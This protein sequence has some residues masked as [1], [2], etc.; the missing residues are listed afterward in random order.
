[1]LD[2]K[3][4][5]LFKI[6]FLL[7]IVGVITSFWVSGNSFDMTHSHLGGF[8]LSVAIPVF[9][10]FGWTSFGLF[11][12]LW[13]QHLAAIEWKYGF[14]ASLTYAIIT[15]GM[16]IGGGYMLYQKGVIF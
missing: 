16:F 2:S 12:G 11:V 1:M 8:L 3:V 9:I 14:G 7:A 10:L 5:V 15:L 6:L 13:F 4:S